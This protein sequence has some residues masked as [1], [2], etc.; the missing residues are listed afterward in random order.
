MLSFVWCVSKVWISSSSLKNYLCLWGSS[1]M[2]LEGT[3]TLSCLQHHPMTPLGNSPCRW[4]AGV[5]ETFAISQ[6]AFPENF[7]SFDAFLKA[8]F[9]R[10]KLFVQNKPKTKHTTNIQEFQS[11]INEKFQLQFC[12]LI[13]FQ[14]IFLS[15]YF[16]CHR[17]RAQNKKSFRS[18]SGS[19]IIIS[20]KCS[21]VK[22]EMP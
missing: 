16:A 12:L 4:T 18:S 15:S 20:S 9:A 2:C 11:S 7:P 13:C 8:I 17:H 3:G 21:F 1:Q 10:P 14:F 5:S 19:E 6:E 22:N